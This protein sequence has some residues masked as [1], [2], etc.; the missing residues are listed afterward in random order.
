[1]NEKATVTK[2]HEDGPIMHNT[3]WDD[4]YAARRNHVR[5]MN[6]LLNQPMGLLMEDDPRKLIDKRAKGI[7]L[8]DMESEYLADCMINDPE[9]AEEYQLNMDLAEM[10]RPK[11]IKEGK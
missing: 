7:A 3:N 11:F 1:M 8:S 4:F 9:L 2:L 10:I 5:R 6:A